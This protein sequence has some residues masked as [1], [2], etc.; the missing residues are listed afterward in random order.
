MHL[1]HKDCTCVFSNRIKKNPTMSYIV[2]YA[3]T[4]SRVHLA[5]HSKVKKVAQLMEKRICCISDASNWWHGRVLSKRQSP[6]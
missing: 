1:L 3:V 2:I 4:E 6:H 5:H